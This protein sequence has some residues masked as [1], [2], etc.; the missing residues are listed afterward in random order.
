MKQ[1]WKIVTH[2]PGSI[3]LLLILFNYKYF[4]ALWHL[5]MQ[6]VLI[7]SKTLKSFVWRGF[8]T[9]RTLSGIVPNATTFEFFEVLT[10]NLAQMPKLDFMTRHICRLII[11]MAIMNSDKINQ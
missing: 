11:I 3:Y 7:F 10:Q 6:V 4:Y 9:F 2:K 1:G 5:H 8:W